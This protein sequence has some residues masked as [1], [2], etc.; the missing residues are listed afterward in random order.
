[1]NFF[2]VTVGVRIKNKKGINMKRNYAGR[3]TKL[4]D[5]LQAEIVNYLKTGNY[6]ETACA[7]AGIS[8]STFYS[9]LNKGKNSTR[10]N[11]YSRFTDAVERAQA[12]AE[13]RLVALIS[14]KA[15][16][17]WQAAAWLLERKHPSKWS[18]NRKEE[19]KPEEISSD[20]SHIDPAD[21][22]I[23]KKVL[24][25]MAKRKVDENSK[26]GPMDVNPKED[27]KS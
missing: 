17:T 22:E 23:V 2:C 18:R 21:R 3:P 11:K 5:E 8:K 27:S 13:A 15:E 16:K 14:K 4:T 19:Q 10:T 7:L 12:W 20:T 24:D 9:W 6:I 25:E 26:S 1:V